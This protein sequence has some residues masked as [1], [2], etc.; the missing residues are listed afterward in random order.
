[1]DQNSS[2]VRPASPHGP[3]ASFRHGLRRASVFVSLVASILLVPLGGLAFAAL[4]QVWRD[5]RTRMRR[6]QRMTVAAYRSLHDWMRIVDLVDFDHRGGLVGMPPG[7]CVVVANHPTLMDITSISA[8]LGG[9]CTIV[10]PA[11][12]RLW[13]LHGLLVGAGHIRGS[14]ADLVSVG[15]IV[16]QAR[17]RLADG[18]CVIVFPEGTRSPAGRL[19]SFGR[20]AFEIAC[21]AQVPLVSLTVECDPLYLSKELDLGQDTAD[22]RLDADR[23]DQGVDREQRHRN[24]QGDQNE[25]DRVGKPQPAMIHPSEN[26][27]QRYDEGDEV[28]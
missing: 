23:G 12:H 17:Q 7:P 9:G 27:G 19:R 26:S 3:R 8:A 15:S 13:C 4:G 14:R 16:D 18:F 10:K 11:L 2:F 24:A 6:M 25:P 22:R 28:E 20:V 1:V 21:Q 5:P